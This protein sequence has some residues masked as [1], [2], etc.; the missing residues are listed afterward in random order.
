MA[1]GTE[2]ACQHGQS[3]IC[4]VCECECECVRKPVD[5]WVCV[6]ERCCCFDLVFR[7]SGNLPTYC[8]DQHKV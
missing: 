4:C 3:W 2:V 5:R 6:C 1:S 8:K 7:L